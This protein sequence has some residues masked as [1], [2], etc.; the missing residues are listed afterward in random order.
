MSSMVSRAFLSICLLIA[1]VFSPAFCCCV[2]RSIAYAD[3][4]LVHAPP[5]SA[6]NKGCPHGRRTVPLRDGDTR[7]GRAHPGKAG[8]DRCHCQDHA[9]ASST[10]DPVTF[11]AARQSD[12]LAS[13]P[14]FVVSAPFVRLTLDVGGPLQADRGGPPPP[15]G[16]AL[17]HRIHVLIC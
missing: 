11:P 1:N 4:S 14:P 8:G 9:V 7:P 2:A 10:P 17:L 12:W 15:A 3:T 13:L 5:Q 16:I 6:A